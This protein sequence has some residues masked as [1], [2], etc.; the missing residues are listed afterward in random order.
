MIILWIMFQDGG[1]GVNQL[2]T[3]TK[4]G[5]RSKSRFIA[6]LGLPIQVNKYEIIR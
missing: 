5:D 1:R 3:V 4:F 6:R 2:E